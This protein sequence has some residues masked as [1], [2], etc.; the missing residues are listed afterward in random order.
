MNKDQHNHLLYKV[1]ALERQLRQGRTEHVQRE[2]LRIL[3]RMVTEI[4]DTQH[5]E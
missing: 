5:K 4:Y 3:A 2:T 1:V